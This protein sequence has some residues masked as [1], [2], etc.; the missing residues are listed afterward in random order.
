MIYPVKNYIKVT[1]KHKNKW[2]LGFG[3][4]TIEEIKTGIERLSKVFNN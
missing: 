3:H 2:I 1:K 4:L